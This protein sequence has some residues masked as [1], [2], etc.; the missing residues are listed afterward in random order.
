MEVARDERAPSVSLSESGRPAFCSPAPQYHK[1][2]AGPC[3]ANARANAAPIPL[4]PPSNNTVLPASPRTFAF[5]DLPYPCFSTAPCRP[6]NRRDYASRT[7]LPACRILASAPVLTSVSARP[8]SRA[9]PRKFAR[10]ATLLI[11]HSKESR[12]G[13]PLHMYN[14][15]TEQ[16]KLSS[17]HA[18][19]SCSFDS[20]KPRGR[21]VT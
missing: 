17:P 19:R 16:V 2:H 6:L 13:A 5:N 12:A 8:D 18:G 15:K 7:N 10:T 3:P 1:R 4:P 9:D 20:V 11:F 21:F 14:A